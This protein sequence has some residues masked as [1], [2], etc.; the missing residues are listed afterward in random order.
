MALFFTLRIE[1]DPA[2]ELDR[3]FGDESSD[4]RIV[5]SGAIVEQTGFR[6]EI[7]PCVLER[8]RDARTPKETGL[9]PL[10]L[11][12]RIVPS[13]EEVL[14]QLANAGAEWTHMGLVPVIP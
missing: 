5:V 9:D 13:Y 11:L 8:I 10:L 6:I 2:L 1:I 4:G 7:S 12:D 14:R 3:V